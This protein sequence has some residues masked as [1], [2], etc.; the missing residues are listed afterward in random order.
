MANSILLWKRKILQSQALWSSVQNVTELPFV[1]W[2][3]QIERAQVSRFVFFLFSP[4]QQVLMLTGIAYW[5]WY[6]YF[7]FNVESIQGQSNRSKSRL[8]NLPKELP[9][10]LGILKQYLHGKH[11]RGK[12]PGNC[13]N[14]IRLGWETEILSNVFRNLKIKLCKVL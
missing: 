12:R 9:D 5:H 8:V 2:L 1:I 7:P 13:Y 11:S 6:N 3:E 10:Y 4:S 14:V